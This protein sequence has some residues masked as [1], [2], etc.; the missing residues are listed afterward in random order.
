MPVS[1]QAGS[2]QAIQIANSLWLKS[3]VPFSQAFLDTNRN[4]FAAAPRALPGDPAGAADAV[5]AW[6]DQRTAGLLGIAEDELPCPWHELHRNLQHPS[7]RP[8][9]VGNS[10]ERVAEVPNQFPPKTGSLGAALNI[11]DGNNVKVVLPWD[12]A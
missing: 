5:N 10:L 3:G 12:R 9:L 2:K 1:Q 6:V 8:D 7:N 4:Y 11:L